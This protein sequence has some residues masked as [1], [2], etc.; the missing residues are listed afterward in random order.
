MDSGVLE[1]GQFELR[2]EGFHGQSASPIQKRFCFGEGMLKGEEER[3]GET[4][5]RKDHEKPID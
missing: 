1:M 3:K 2:Q 5:G 4:E